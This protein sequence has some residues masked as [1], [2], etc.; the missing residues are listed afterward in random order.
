VTVTA[1]TLLPLAVAGQAT[2]RTTRDRLELL[3]ALITAPTFDP[4]LR[5]DVMEVPRDHPTYGWGCGVPQCERS[6]D[7]SHQ[8][9][10]Q[11]HELDWRARK[12]AGQNIAE[13]LASVAPLK[14]YQWLSPPPCLVCPDL[15][16]RSQSQLC[17]CHAHQWTSHRRYYRE[18]YGREADFDAWVAAEQPF[19]SFGK[20]QV[21]SCPDRA[22]HPLGLCHR[23]RTGYI[24]QGRP[25][26]ART[27]R[28]WSH[29][30]LRTGEPTPVSYDDE[31][32]F[33]RWCQESD[34]PLRVNGTLSL[35]GLRPLVKA[36]I[37]W[38]M[39]RHTQGQEGSVWPVSW[40]Q[41]VVDECRRQSVSS[42]A[43]LDLDP[44]KVHVR[45]IAKVMLQYLRLVYFTREDTREAGFIE[46]EHYGI[47]FRN[48][49]SHIDL[50]RITQR[51][52]RDMCWDLMDAR[53]TVG[54]V[55]SRAPFDFDRRGCVELSAYLEVEA[56]AG[57]HDPTLLTEAHVVN[58]VADQRHRARHR[59]KSLA[60]RAC[61]GAQ[62]PVT[63]TEV[64]MSTVFGG[65]RR[66]LRSGMESGEAERVGLQRRFII[67]LPYGPKTKGR[68]KPFSDEVARALGSEENLKRL[69]ASDI[70]DRGLRDIWEGLV[71]TGRRCSEILNV[72]LECVD[73]QGKVP[74]FWHDQTKVGNF[75]EGIRI[76]ERFY[77]LVRQ[78]QVKTIARFVQ[79]KGRPPTAEERR[80]LALFPRKLTNRELVKGASYGWFQSWFKQWID[81]LD[82]ERAVPHQALAPGVRLRPVRRLIRQARQA[83]NNGTGVFGGD[84]VRISAK[85]HFESSAGERQRVEVA[86]EDR[87]SGIE[88]RDSA[89]RRSRGATAAGCCW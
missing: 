54:Q 60:T 85:D 83:P 33:L 5:A 14:Q 12:R 21:V 36:E 2:S 84:T 23:H 47:R 79:R 57:G 15:P 20:C 67:T 49:S 86:W 87:L 24:R 42:L 25:G 30:L 68:R 78:R 80:E 8:D 51:W 13:F 73:R 58:F 27:P 17:Y 52:L 6:R 61:G 48:T 89:L 70:E 3:T 22:D 31:A 11:E 19:P 40:I 72:R 38:C 77:E 44:C 46:T 74:M 71:V 88:C 65:A 64:T 59:L 39:F 75:D 76:P 29:E 43:D 82:I 28:R 66:V 10:C 69:A 62:M 81:S 18:K 26:G 55:R 9:F 63:V 41:R 4:V 35:L 50:T 37:K 16:A 7:V 1:R 45:Q 32:R 56:P 34:P 53:L